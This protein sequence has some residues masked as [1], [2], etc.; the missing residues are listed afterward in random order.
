METLERAVKQ[1]CSRFCVIGRYRKKVKLVLAVSAVLFLCVVLSGLI[2]VNVSSVYQTS[3]TISSVGTL[4]TIGVGV[5]SKNDLSSK[6]SVIDWGVL[7]PGGQ[8]TFTIYVHNEGIVPLTLSMSVSNWSPSA[9]SNYLTLTWN[10]AEQ[11]ISQGETV[12]ATLTLVV[13]AAT[14]GINSFNFDINVV[15][16]V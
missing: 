14:T 4:K 6:L 15:G 5:Y 8:K 12:K 10:P 3:S 9:A 16:T 2:I 13:S 1:L 7:T 11:T